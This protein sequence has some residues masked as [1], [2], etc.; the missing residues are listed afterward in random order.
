M[1]QDG[2]MADFLEGAAKQAEQRNPMYGLWRGPKEFYNEADIRWRCG[3]EQRS[4]EYSL[5]HRPN[6]APLI[7][8]R[9]ACE[10]DDSKWDS[11]FLQLQSICAKTAINC[12]NPKTWFFVASVDI[13]SL[14]IIF[15]NDRMVIYGHPNAENMHLAERGLIPCEVMAIFWHDRK[16][17]DVVLGEGVQLPSEISSRIQT[18]LAN[19]LDPSEVIEMISFRNGICYINWN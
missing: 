18:C 17:K 4:E 16:L 10:L 1:R 11:L 15:Y 13:Q 5:V 12:A 8:G 14:D 3:L 7:P 19:D 6:D 2:D 9:Q